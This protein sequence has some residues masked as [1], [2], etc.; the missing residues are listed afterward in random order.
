MPLY[1]LILAEEMGSDVY[2]SFSPQHS[3]VKIKDENDAWYNI[4][5]TCRAILTDAHYM[6]NGYIKAEALRNRI[7]LE[8]MDKT[9]AIAEIL[10]RLAGEYYR[11]YGFDDFYLKCIETAEP[12]LSNNLNAL[13][14]RSAYETELTLTLAQLLRTPTPANMKEEYPEAYKHFELMLSL[15]KQIDATGYEE[16]PADLYAR[17]LDHVAKEKEKSQKEKQPVFLQRKGK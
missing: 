9:N 5:L 8:P 2:W 16:L 15:Y 14:C 11:K 1:F 7:Y 12:Y 17:W 6:N 4:E 3:F 10:I 13:R